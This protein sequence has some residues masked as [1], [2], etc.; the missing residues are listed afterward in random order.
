MYTLNWVCDLI[1]IVK[2]S[3]LL[4]REAKLVV[5]NFDGFIQIFPS[6]KKGKKN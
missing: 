6:C 5:P 1:K 2:E 3:F 4:I